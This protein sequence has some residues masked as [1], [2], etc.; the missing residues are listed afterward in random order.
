MSKLVAIM[1][2]S[3]DAPSAS[4]T[5]AWPTCYFETHSGVPRIGKAAPIHVGARRKSSKRGMGTK[6]DEAHR[7][8]GSCRPLGR[9]V[10]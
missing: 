2:R 4:S 9:A 6:H 8:S 1:S 7:P 10:S 3:L 5:M